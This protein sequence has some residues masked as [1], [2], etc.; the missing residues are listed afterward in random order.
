MLPVPT[1][2]NSTTG[3]RQARQSAPRR[4]L[5][6]GVTRRVCLHLSLFSLQWCCSMKRLYLAPHHVGTS[7]RAH[8]YT[9]RKLTRLLTPCLLF[10]PSPGLPRIR[11]S[12]EGGRG[13]EG[14]QASAACTVSLAR[15]LFHGISCTVSLSRYLLHAIFA[16]R[17][18]SAGPR[19]RLVP[20]ACAASLRVRWRGVAFS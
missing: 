15:Y 11:F 19:P 17:G 8:P 2:P 5:L 12:P 9:T 20:I 1:W 3:R 6:H 14:A 7:P 4:L 16:P 13:L 10:A 18:V